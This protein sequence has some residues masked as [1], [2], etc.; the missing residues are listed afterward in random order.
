[1]TGDMVIRVDA[2]AAFV[3]LIANID[4]TTPIVVPIKALPSVTSIP[5]LD[6]NSLLTSGHPLVRLHITKIPTRPPKSLISVA[7]RAGIFSRP[8]LLNKTPRA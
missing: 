6:V 5:C 8:T 7:G 2:T 1:M 3:Y 4:R